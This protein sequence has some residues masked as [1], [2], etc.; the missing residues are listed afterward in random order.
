MPNHV[1]TRLTASEVVLNFAI[2]K[3]SFF[4]CNK[5]IPQPENMETGGCS[6]THEPGVVCWYEWNIENWGTKWGTYEVTRAEEFVTFNTAWSHPLPV[7]TALSKMFPDEKIDVEY[8]DEDL[9]RNLRKYT[10][11][12][13]VVVQETLFDEEAALDFASQMIYGKSYTEMLSEWEED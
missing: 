9:G 5:I 3:E 7:V 6:G 1:T 13:G 10:M 12:N 11:R 8:A 4:D 2:G